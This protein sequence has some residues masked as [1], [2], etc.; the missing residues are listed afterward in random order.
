MRL[1]STRLLKEGD[2]IG[3]DIVSHEGGVLLKHDTRFKEA[4]KNK[5]LER[6]VLEV[7][8]KDE[9]SEGIEPAEIISQE[10][11]QII[12]SDIK[13]QYES[14]K[15]HFDIDID[16]LTKV[17][18]LLIE[19][20]MQKDLVFEL[21][22]I[23]TN[24]NY[25]YEHCIAV[26][27]MSHLVCDKL[28]IP[29]E[30]KKQIVLGALIHDIGK[31]IIPKDVLNKPGRLT[32]EEYMMMRTHAEVGYSMIK[33]NP[34]IHA[35]TKLVVLCHHEREDGSGYPLGKGPELHIGAK[36]VGA[37]DLF[38]ALISNRCY[39][40]GLPVNE[41]IAIAQNE[42]IN[43]QIRTIIEHSLA[44]YPVGC[45]VQ[46]NDGSIA[47]VEKNF[48]AD[49]KKPLVRVIRRDF[50]GTKQDT[51]KLDLRKEIGYWIEKRYMGKI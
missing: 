36:I 21:D 46:L 31:V 10:S 18:N 19:E 42:P 37:C 50:N 13:A 27:M 12:M 41:V 4:F 44:Y 35:I 40:Q 16:I 26:A 20:L 7:Y 39:R 28:M 11:K 23:K 32:D 15:N 1:I 49:V 9:V 24:D 22:D 51:Y 33:D 43:P 8:I 14:L 3:R 47:I 25:T 38:H 30:Q 45:M 34:S 48:A 2:I 29:M 6:D 17:T 5:L